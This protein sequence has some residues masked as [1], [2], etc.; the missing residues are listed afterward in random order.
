MVRRDIPFVLTRQDGLAAALVRHLPERCVVLPRGVLDVLQCRTLCLDDARLDH[1]RLHP[2]GRRGELP[3][4]TDDHVVFKVWVI[5]RVGCLPELMEPL[6]LTRGPD[7]RCLWCKSQ[8]LYFLRT[9]VVVHPLRVLRVANDTREVHLP[10]DAEAVANHAHDRN[11][12]SRPLLLLQD[13][14]TVSLDPPNL[15]TGRRALLDGRPEIHLV[16][17]ILALILE[18]GLTLREQVQCLGFGLTIEVFRDSDGLVVI[19]RCLVTNTDIHF[20]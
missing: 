10:L 19:P 3:I 16:L 5:L 4:I 2:L 13:L 15:L 11:T 7:E 1:R 14:V 9:L 12:V 20:E 8:H 18:R 17:E 6:E